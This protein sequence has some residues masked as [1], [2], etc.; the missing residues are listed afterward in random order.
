MYLLRACVGQASA[1]KFEALLEINPRMDSALRNLALALW[2]ASS[3]TDD[4]R[5]QRELIEDATAAFE[6]LLQL[7]P[8]DPTAIE[9]L[10]EIERQT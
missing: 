3:I 4:I 8:D 9:I 7:V 5:E 1:E 6:E 2:E 10:Q